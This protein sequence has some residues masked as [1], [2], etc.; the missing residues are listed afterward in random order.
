MYVSTNK[1]NNKKNDILYK[2]NFIKLTP[3]QTWV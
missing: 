3:T 2:N 1:D